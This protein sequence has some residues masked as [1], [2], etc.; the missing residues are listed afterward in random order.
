MLNPI[1]VSK[2]IGL[3]SVAVLGMAL[4]MGV[5][6][7]VKAESFDVNKATV[8]FDHPVEVPGKVLPPGTY[9][10]KSLEDNGL[11]QVF[12]GDEHQLFATLAVVPTDRPAHD[13]DIDSFIQLNK[14]R[15]DAPQE[16]EGFFL[17]G[18]L[19]GFQFVYPAT[20]AVRHR[21]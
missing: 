2:F 6:S 3:S 16:V 8:T 20:H 13:Q 14:T 21:S 11:V 12:S 4:L 10:F 15:A 18:R 7:P 5:S 9:V 17:P 1:R 19:T